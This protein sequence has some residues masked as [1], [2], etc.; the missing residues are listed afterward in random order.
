MHKRFAKALGAHRKLLLLF[1]VG[2]ILVSLVI[3]WYRFNQAPAE[4]II[5]P[6]TDLEA[7][8]TSAKPA[9]PQHFQGLAVA[10][11]YPAG[12]RL[13]EANPVVTP[14]V[15]AHSFSFRDGLQ[16]SRRLSIT[17]KKPQE[18]VNI[19]EDSAYAFRKLKTDTYEASEAVISGHNV[20]KMTKKD[21]TEI[22]YFIPHGQAYAI[23]T[24]TTT[25]PVDSKLPDDILLVVST[26]TWL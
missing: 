3:G 10:F 21:G 4:G 15:E 19:T 14:V 26:L 23:L 9:A 12:Y 1:T 25:N 5:K 8:Q 7:K 22:T 16:E 6:S 20:K 13:L 17:V 18:V 24:G 2:L 11:N